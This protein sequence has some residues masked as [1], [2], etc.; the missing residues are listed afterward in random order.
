MTARA[1]HAAERAADQAAKQA[2]TARAALAQ[3]VDGRIASI[4]P[5]TDVRRLAYE[6]AVADVEQAQRKAD[7][8][9]E[10]LTR[11]REAS[12]PKPD[13]KTAR[14]ALKV[15]I[16]NSKR[17]A[18]VASNGRMSI[19][20][21]GELVSAAER[22]LSEAEAGLDKARETDARAAA[23][24]AA[25]GAPARAS[26]MAKARARVT[27][28]QDALDAAKGAAALATNKQGELDRAAA[29]AQR[30]VEQ[31][32]HQVIVAEL[33][34]VL[35]EEIAA[36]HAAYVGKR[37]L[38]RQLL[39]HDLLDEP[40]KQAALGVLRE[41]IIPAPGG[42]EFRQWDQH[43]VALAFAEMRKALSADADTPVELLV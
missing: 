9:V 6:R 27:E 3:E 34:A 32:V 33:P 12:E 7:Q 14:A 26:A 10:R 41:E 1:V 13:A 40:R 8:A 15:A 4:L 36:M 11:A 21:A 17:A 25:G 24:V 31:L 5:T 18:T 19:E 30:A 42:G 20:R 2:L 23:K 29:L 43:P 16:A 37:V 28:M 38:L 22:K 35:V 39:R